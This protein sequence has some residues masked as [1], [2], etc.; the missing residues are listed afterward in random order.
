MDDFLEISFGRDVDQQLPC[1]FCLEIVHNGGFTTD[2]YLYKQVFYKIFISFG[3]LTILEI[4]IGL[5]W[6]LSVFCI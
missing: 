4:Q 3:M 2:V 1:L 5:G 6:K